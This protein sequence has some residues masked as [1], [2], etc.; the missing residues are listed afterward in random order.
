MGL[1]TRLQ[2]CS[3]WTITPIDTVSYHPRGLQ[4][5]VQGPPKHPRCELR[6][7]GKGHLFWHV[8]LST[9]LR[10]LCPTLRQIQLSIHKSMT[11]RGCICQKDSDL[12]VFYS[13]CR[14]AILSLNSHRLLPLF[15]KAGFIQDIYPI[16]IS[17]CLPH[18]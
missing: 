10:V 3:Q 17:Y 13:S 18:I 9:P 4:S 11:S 12:A 14:S 7:R 2:T 8:R 6:F 1:F 15:E 5:C 16:G